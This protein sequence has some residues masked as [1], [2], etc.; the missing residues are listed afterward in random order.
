V[1]I[2]KEKSMFDGTNGWKKV[3][4]LYTKWKR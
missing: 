2:L 1:L 4:L 3:W